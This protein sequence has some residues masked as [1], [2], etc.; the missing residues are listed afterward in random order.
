MSEFAMNEE[1]PR[2][3]RWPTPPGLWLRLKPEARR[4]RHQPTAAESILWASLRNRKLD[5]FRFRRQ[6]AIGR[7]IVDFY[8]SDLK[9]VLEVDGQIHKGRRDEDEA[10]DKFLAE[11]G[12]TVL[13]FSNDR[14]EGALD[15]V[16]AEISEA[17]IVGA[18]D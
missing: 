6:H 3:K 11:R 1:E 7:F 10:R 16:L 12:L 2:L 13:L 4:M 15:G 17:S 18:D 14:V 8:C 5:G 9:L